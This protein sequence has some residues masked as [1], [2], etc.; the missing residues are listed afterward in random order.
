MARIW[1]PTAELSHQTMHSI[2]TKFLFFPLYRGHTGAASRLPIQM[3]VSVGI[4]DVPCIAPGYHQRHGRPVATDP[5]Q[6][7]P[8]HPDHR[9]RCSTLGAPAKP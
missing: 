2:D 7:R 5:D 8:I 4:T 9:G 6:P 1:R 3:R